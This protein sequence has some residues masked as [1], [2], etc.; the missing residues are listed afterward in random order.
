M[1]VGLIDTL[2]I[3]A[4][5]LNFYALGVT[6][7]RSVIQGVAIQGVLLGFLPLLVESEVS[8]RGLL[9]VLAIVTLKGYLIPKMLFNAIRD[10]SFQREIQPFVGFVPCLLI[11]AVGTGTAIDLSYRLPMEKPHS[12]LLLVPV[13]MA[14]V[15]TGFLIMMTRKRSVL[16]VC[17]YLVLEN[18][19]FTFG[20]LLLE[21]IP[22]L[23]ELGVLL[24]LFTCVFVMG[25]TIQ[26]VNREFSSIST[27]T[28]S[29]LKE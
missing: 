19:I 28:L 21:A 23:V 14:T 11:L 1:N 2:L 27:E 15:F 17:G 10:V 13:S 22:L 5:V 8:V 3:F 9:L 29:E 6:G 24:D 26:N 7:V 25:L 12:A 4:V 16:Q 18:G 20:L